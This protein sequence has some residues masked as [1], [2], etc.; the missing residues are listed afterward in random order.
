MLDQIAIFRENAAR[1][2][3]DKKY[4]EEER[5][6][7]KPGAPKASALSAYGYGTR[8]LPKAAETRAPPGK[9]ATNGT[10]GQGAQHT[11]R[12]QG[13][14][15][16]HG[17]NKADPQN[18]SEP[19]NFVRPETVEGKGSSERTDEEEEMIRQQRRERDK[20]MALREKESRVEARERQ[21]VDSALREEATRQSRGE[22]EA[23]NR[24]RLADQLAKWD[25]DD[26]D[27]HDLFLVDRSQWRSQ[28]QKQRIREEKED[29]EDRRQEDAEMKALEAESEDF[30]QKQ[31]AEL[32]ARENK[33]RQ[34]G[35]LTEDAAPI[36]LAIAAKAVPE[37]VVEKKPLPA[38]APPA[39]ALGDEEEENVVHKKK[40]AL[41]KLEYEQ[42]LDQAEEEAKAK[43][44]LLAITKQLPESTRAFDESIDWRAIAKVRTKIDA[45][46]Q[47]KIREALGEVD[48]DLAQFVMEHIEARKGPEELVDE[49]SPVLAE[50]AEGVVLGLWRQLILESQAAEHGISSGDTTV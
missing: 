37:P 47:R 28:R 48:E 45:F 29:V 18:Y 9:K 4:L 40:R 10:H 8:A 17:A 1:R 14:Y 33:G 32:E 39:L 6:Q 42:S 20:A 2:E 15:A 25:D 41:V 11:Q 46:V 50:E 24:R 44:R 31:Q 19:V 43:A 5:E 38:P 35:L 49:L 16:A 30:L 26:E 12:E 23:R 13:S 27:N 7:Y 21:R 34:I 3:R 36:K 22:N